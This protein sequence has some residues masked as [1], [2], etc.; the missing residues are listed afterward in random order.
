MQ[1]ACTFSKMTLS[2][3]QVVFC[4]DAMVDSCML[5][6]TVHSK[7]LPLYRWKASQLPLTASHGWVRWQRKRHFDTQ[8][9]CSHL[10][11]LWQKR[12]AEMALMLQICKMWMAYSMTLNTQR[13]C[14]LN[15]QTSTSLKS[16]WICIL[17]KKDVIDKDISVCAT[18][19][20]L[21]L[22][23]VILMGEFVG[24]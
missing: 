1:I 8:C 12:M 6:H 10:Q 17:A 24:S 18:I 19:A 15:K 13:S 3:S 11:Q 4:L 20:C 16:G 7:L 21:E 5:A 9:S 22:C 23:C 2:T 14:W